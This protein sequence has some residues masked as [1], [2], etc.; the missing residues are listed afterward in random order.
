MDQKDLITIYSDGGS[1]GNPGPAGIGA[2]IKIGTRTIRLAELIGVAT[3]NIAEYSAIIRALEEALRVAGES[4][5][6]L[7]VHCYLDSELVVKQVRREYK[8]KDPGL[9]KL[10][11]RLWNLTLG[12]GTVKFFHIKRELNK[13]ADKLVNQALDH[14]FKR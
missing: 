5:S 12:F 14:A 13:E 8:V 11:V 6:T 9:A 2:V 3:N 4:A 1:R 10:F 7:E